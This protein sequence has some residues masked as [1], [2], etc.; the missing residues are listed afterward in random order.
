MGILPAEALAALAGLALLAATGGSLQ[1]AFTPG[2]SASGRGAAQPGSLAAA[3]IIA[4]TLSGVSF[5]GIGAAF[6]GILAGLAVHGLEG[7]R[8]AG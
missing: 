1:A 8:R 6:W 4:V 7:V 5:F 3:V 2:Q